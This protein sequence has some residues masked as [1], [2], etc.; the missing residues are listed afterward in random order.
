MVLLRI[1]KGPKVPDVRKT[2][3]SDNSINN[4]NGWPSQS[5]HHVLGMNPVIFSHN[6]LEQGRLLSLVLRTMGAK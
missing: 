2:N 5:E 1:G 6:C 3:N 4:N